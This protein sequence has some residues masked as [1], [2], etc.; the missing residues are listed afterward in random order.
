MSL[1]SE[2]RELAGVQDPV[3]MGEMTN[4]LTDFKS[5]PKRSYETQRLKAL[6][7]QD[8]WNRFKPEILDP[9]CEHI[10][11]SPEA[12]SPLLKLEGAPSCM[13]WEAVL[14]CSV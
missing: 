12:L 10:P 13:I 3:G 6:L 2:R 4:P 7:H 5:K 11:T 9:A 14:Q 8:G 1:D